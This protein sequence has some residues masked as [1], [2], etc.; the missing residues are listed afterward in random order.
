MAHVRTQIRD[1][2]V[3]LLTG[4]A[5]TGSRVHSARVN[6][7]PETPALSVFVDEEEIEL[8]VV[9]DPLQ[10]S[11]AVNV[12]V[13]CHSALIDGLDDKLDQMALE[14]EQAVAADPTLTG[15]LTDVL[16]PT[17]IEVDRTP[18]GE[19]PIGKLTITFAASY[20]TTNTA[21]DTVL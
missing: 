17:G 16:R 14:V 6:A 8:A 13:E 7:V 12:R 3:A 1:A 19:T 20:E 5:T 15:W 10:L 9:T 11:R 4:L 2:L 21:P 18:R